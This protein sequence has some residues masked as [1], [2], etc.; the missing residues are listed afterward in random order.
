MQQSHKQSKIESIFIL[1]KNANQYVKI[2]LKKL[3]KV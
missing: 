1:E 2:Y 3:Y